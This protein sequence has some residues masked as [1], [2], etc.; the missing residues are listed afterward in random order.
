MQNA[1]TM[2]KFNRTLLTFDALVLSG[3]SW[4]QGTVKL[5]WTILFL[6]HL[7]KNFGNLLNIS[8]HCDFCNS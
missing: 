6:S 4:S 7:Y 3:F 2:A 5:V 8:I 1:L